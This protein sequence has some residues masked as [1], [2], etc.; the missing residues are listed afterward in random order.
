M[1]REMY[2]ALSGG[3]RSMRSLDVLAN[4][5]ANVNTTGF[6]ADRVRFELVSPDN[7][8]GK[9]TAAGRLGESFVTASNEVTD[10]AQGMLQDTG[11]P[12]DLA[13][14][15]ESGFFQLAAPDGEGPPMLTRSGAFHLDPE[16]YLTAQGG[17]RVLDTG[18]QPLQVD[19]RGELLI[20]HDGVVTVG[21][22]TIG[23]IGIVDVADRTQLGK[24]GSG[25]WTAPADAVLEP[26]AAEVIQGHLESSNVEPVQALTEL[27]AITRY[28][29]AFQKNLDASSKLDEALNSQVGR[30][31]R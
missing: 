20:D 4:N 16:G 26:A 1:G 6:K 14:R 24:S 8:A 31:D 10:Y 28:F 29:E 3:L 12:T 17:Y 15:G 30:L 2:P 23:Q 19:G 7:G 5:L 18:G 11:N 27:I 21:E 13:L 25:R 9:G 22:A